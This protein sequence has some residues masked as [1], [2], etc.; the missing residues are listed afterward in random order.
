VRP[1]ASVAKV[2]IDLL[3]GRVFSAVGVITTAE[4]AINVWGE[5]EYLKRP[6]MWASLGLIV[7]AV[8][9][10]FINFWFGRAWPAGYA[11]HAFSVLLVL[12]AWPVQVLPDAQLPEHFR[13]WPWWATGVASMAASMYLPR[14]WA[15]GFMVAMP[16][17]WM[18]IHVQPNGGGATVGQVIQDG[19]YIV[20]FS[21]AI[22]VLVTLLRQ[23]AERVDQANQE[24]LEAAA[25]RARVD[26]LERERLRLDALVHDSV[27]T[28]LLL[29][30]NARD[31]EQEHLAKESADAAIARI[32]GAAVELEAAGERITVSSFFD[33]LSAAVTRQDPTVEVVSSGANLTLIP[34]EV[35][36]A[37]TEATVQAIANSIQ[38]AGRR[39][40]R[41]LRLKVE[42]KGIKIVIKDDGVGFRPGRVP[43]SRLGLRISIIARVEAVGGKVFIE[44]KIG[45]GTTIVIEWGFA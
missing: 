43:K 27:L 12:L 18:A 39:A 4:M 33:A 7:F 41:L 6:L 38:H 28:T 5:H 1:G 21:A 13:P 34:A 17:T 11:V 24:S 45:G 32:E 37:I 15:Y 9:A 30:A 23:S 14:W 19:I 31:A 20:T 42:S 26:A 8:L 44:S 25:E 16:M 35:A 3:V 40:R 10:N 22:A 2:G 36:V 29:A